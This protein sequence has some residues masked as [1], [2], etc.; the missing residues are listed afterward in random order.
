MVELTADRLV[1]V[2]NGGA[3]DYPGSIDDYID[4]VLGRN[5]P[6]SAAKAKPKKLTARDRD[7]ARALKQAASGRRRC[8]RKTG[9]RMRRPRPR[10]RRGRLRQGDRAT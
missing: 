9:R 7:E 1:L 5:Q 8:E 6:K 4:F 3:V 10:T 2:D